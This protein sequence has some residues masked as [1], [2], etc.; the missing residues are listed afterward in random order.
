MSANRLKLIT[1]KTQLILL[2]TRQQLVRVKRKSVSLDGVDIAFSD[3]VTCLG[4][5]FDNDLKFST[6]MKQS[7][8]KCFYHLRQ[9][10]SVRR[11]LS[12]DAAK[13]K[14][15]VNAFII[16]RIDYCN[17]I[18]SRVTATHLRPQ[19]SVLNAAARLIVKKCKY[20]PIIATV[21]DVL[22]WLPIQRRIEYRLCDLVHKA[23]HRT[24]PV[25]LT[26][27]CVHVSIHQGRANLRSATYIKSVAANKG[28]IY[29]RRS[30]AVA[31]PA[32]WNTP[33]LST[34][35]LA[36]SYG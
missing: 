36:L 31:G 22:Y 33:S 32:T 11:S 6:H 34:R 9:M 27:L 10:R 7:A 12:V 15:L 35:E 16:S 4:V 13:T 29:D 8:G 30:F 24:A 20:D 17:R 25:Y 1:D 5:V 2:G 18:F 3:D 28:T 23:M 26:E 14:I 21:R 19:Q